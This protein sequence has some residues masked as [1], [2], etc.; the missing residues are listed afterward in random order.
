MRVHSLVNN[1]ELSR[2]ATRGRKIAISPDG[3]FLAT[4]H[5][6][7]G[8]GGSWRINV[9]DATS[10]QH[11]CHLTEHT[12]PITR[13]A[14]ASDGLLYSCDARGVIRVWNVERQCEQWSFSMLNWASNNSS[15]CE[16][17]VGG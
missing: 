3:R 2:Q 14:F 16:A 5:C 6:T 7:I 8:A 9:Y 11:L 12:V 17:S 10:G 4:D 1:E 15:F 13:L